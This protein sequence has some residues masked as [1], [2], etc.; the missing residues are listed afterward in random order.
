M[1]KKT[2]LGFCKRGGKETEMK[3]EDR[4]RLIDAGKNS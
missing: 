3:T 2:S 1:E 4:K